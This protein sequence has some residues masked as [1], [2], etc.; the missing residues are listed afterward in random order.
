R[1]YKGLDHALLM[2]AV[3]APLRFLAP[4]LRDSTDFMRARLAEADR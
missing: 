4:V 1:T 2:G 3:A